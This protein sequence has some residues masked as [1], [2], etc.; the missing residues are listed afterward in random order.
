MSVGR[1]VRHA[2]FY[3]KTVLPLRH[4][5]TRA[6]CAFYSNP[7]LSYTIGLSRHGLPELCFDGPDAQRA[8]AVLDELQRRQFAHGAFEP[9]YVTQVGDVWVRLD[10]LDDPEDLPL[11]G[12]VL[13]LDPGTFSAL[14]VVAL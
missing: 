8:F 5:L 2:A 12:L 6:R 7:S 10:V 1:L 3:V 11:V 14:R 13:R 9:G 4:V